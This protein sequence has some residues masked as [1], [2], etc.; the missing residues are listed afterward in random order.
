MRVRGDLDWFVMVVPVVN[1]QAE[2]RLFF[3]SRVEGG[4]PNR[5]EIHLRLLDPL[6]QLR[7]DIAIALDR[8]VLCWEERI[9]VLIR[10]L[11]GGGG[12]SRDRSVAI[13]EDRRNDLW[14]CVSYRQPTVGQ[15]C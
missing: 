12:R 7:K 9:E 2:R 4:G 3:G 5:V 15:L 8:A 14:E 11:E 10:Q 13:P 1:S 6:V